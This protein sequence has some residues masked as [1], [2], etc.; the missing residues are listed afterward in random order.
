MLPIVP[1]QNLGWVQPYAVA[2]AIPN[3]SK[4]WETEA[5]GR[6]LQ[7]LWLKHFLRSIRP[8]IPTSNLGFQKWPTLLWTLSESCH[9]TWNLCLQIW[10][11]ATCGCGHL[12]LPTSAWMMHVP[13]PGEPRNLVDAIVGINVGDVGA[14]A[15]EMR[16]SLSCQHSAGDCT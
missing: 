12:W 7:Y 6:Q 16:E 2:V 11:M 15:S 1:K 5:P 9:V 13:E 3:N 4:N 10:H 8:E 14:K